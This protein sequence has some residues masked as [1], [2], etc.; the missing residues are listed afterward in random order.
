VP[1]HAGSGANAGVIAGSGGMPSRASAG[2]NL[3]A[4]DTPRRTYLDYV[5]V[6]ASGA[7]SPDSSHLPMLAIW[8]NQSAYGSVRF[9]SFKPGD[10][11][12]P[13]QI[14]A[15]LPATQRA[16]K[17]LSITDDPYNAAPAPADAAQPIQKALDAAAAMATASSPVDVLVPAGTFNYGK[18]L[19]VGADVRLRRFPEDTG[20]TLHATKPSDAAIHLAGDRSGALFLALNF[21][22]TRRETS[23]QASGIWVGGDNG[24]SPFVHDVLV[25][26]NDVAQSASAHLFGFAEDGAIW[27]FNSAH[28][29]YADAF[30][31]T[32]GSR[33]CQVVGNRAQTAADRGDDLYAFVSYQDDGDVVHHCACIANWG[34]DGA[35]RGLSVVG[36]G[37]IVFDHNDIDRTQWAGVYL[38]QENSYRTY[39]V[40]DLTV[41][42]N[43]IAHANQNGSHDGLL[44]YADAPG[45]SHDSVSFGSVSN[46][47]RRISV[48][49]NVISDTSAGIGNGFGIEIRSGIDTGEVT[50][51]VLSGN[52]PPQLVVNGT[53]FTTS[54]NQTK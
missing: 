50:G 17:S 53:N 44:V 1:A 35:A 10:V 12:T 47:V 20:G 41:S 22:A 16:T 30:H 2:W 8:E 11:L 23:A 52:K 19:R 31:H 14:M 26:G 27:A 21:A 38:A 36:G 18:T 54:N 42:R 7:W 45:E 29:G 39:G 13:T 6:P 5:E 24:A 46:R 3:V 33:F 28:D 51:N 37:F 43:Q 15:L 9:Q 25:V 32:G 49:E 48:R 34:R 4:I 40:F